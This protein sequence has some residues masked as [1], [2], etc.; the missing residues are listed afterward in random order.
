MCLVD[1]DD[2]VLQT[3]SLAVVGLAL[4]DCWVQDVVVRAEDDIGIPS[5]DVGGVV[6]TAAQGAAER[7]DFTRSSKSQTWPG[8]AQVVKTRLA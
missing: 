4:G 5:E 6:G 3:P 1:D 8:A 7:D 2:P